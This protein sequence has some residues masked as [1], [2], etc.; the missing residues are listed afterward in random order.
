MFCSMSTSSTKRWNVW[1]TPY[2]LTKLDSGWV[3]P[4]LNWL[5]REFEDMSGVDIIKLN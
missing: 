5:S 3:L 4:L 1:Q 2:E